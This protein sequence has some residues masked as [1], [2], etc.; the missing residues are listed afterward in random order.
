L[1]DK[2]TTEV[3]H[4]KEGTTEA[5]D[6]FG[7]ESKKIVPFLLHRIQYAQPNEV[8]MSWFLSYQ[9]TSQTRNEPM[10]DAALDSMMDMATTKTRKAKKRKLPSNGDQDDNKTNNNDDSEMPPAESFTLPLLTHCELVNSLYDLERNGFIA[11][12]KGDKKNVTI[13]KTMYT[14]IN[15]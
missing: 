8:A 10:Q 11:M 9:Q 14:G 3:S 2:G 1:D 13:V 4:P 15:V 7:A 6:F 5:M 12:K